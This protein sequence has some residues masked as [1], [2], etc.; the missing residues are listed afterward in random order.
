MSPFFHRTESRRY[1]DSS[2]E[3]WEYVC[4]R[5]EYRARYQLDTQKGEFVLVVIAEGDQHV[6]HLNSNPPL[7]QLARPLQVLD[8]LAD[9]QEEVDCPPAILP[10]HIV[11]QVE[12]ILQRLGFD[13]SP[14]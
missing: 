8:Q 7:R 4:R 9:G 5:C 6:Q 11:R 2:G 12:A 13:G 3:G 14:V 1:R 10:Y